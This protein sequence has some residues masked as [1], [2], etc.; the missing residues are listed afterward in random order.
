MASGGKGLCQTK[1]AFAVSYRVH[2]ARGMAELYRL[3]TGT[4]RFGTFVRQPQKIGACSMQGLDANKP[5]RER[6]KCFQSG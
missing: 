4:R 1:H 2:V 3:R 5:L 6:R